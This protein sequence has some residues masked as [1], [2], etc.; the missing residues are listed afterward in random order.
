MLDCAKKFALCMAYIGMSTGLIR[1]NKYLMAEGRFPYSMTLTAIHMAFSSI[2]CLLLYCVN[3]NFFPGMAA[4]VGRRH[5]VV[6]WFVPI[7]IAFAVS[8]YASN[9]AYLYC[10]VT[11]LQFLK[12]GNVVITF[13]MSVAAGLQVMTRLRAAIIVWV[14]TGSSFAVSGE[15]QFAWI[16]FAFQVVSQFAE[17]SRAVMGEH[18][19]TGANLKLDPLSYTL[20]ISPTCLTVLLVGNA[21]EWDPAIPQALVEWW[22]VLLPNACMAF[23]LNVIVAT[24]IKEMSAVGFI[25]NGVVKDIVVVLASAVLFG[26]S[27]TLS[28][29]LGFVLTLAGVFCWSML[30]LDPDNKVIRNAE[31]FFGDTRKEAEN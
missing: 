12:E 15:V 30:K 7:G 16:G 10:N 28:Q 9:Q 6:R 20:F 19:L 14:I 27:V 13:L 3:P 21:F 31:W 11:F 8:L 24:V 25:M 22:P 26:E 29:T 5:T 17:C 1:F 18:V 2:L 23:L 4:T